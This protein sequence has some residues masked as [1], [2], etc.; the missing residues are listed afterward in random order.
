M[1]RLGQ[2]QALIIVLGDFVI[3]AMKIYWN[4]HIS[5]INEELTTA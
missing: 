2:R 1:G 4:V 5:S 3:E